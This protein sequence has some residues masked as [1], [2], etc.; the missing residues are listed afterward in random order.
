MCV[1]VQCEGERS[2]HYFVMPRWD[3]MAGYV[4]IGCH[5]SETDFDD[6]YVEIS[7]IQNSAFQRMQKVSGNS[8]KIW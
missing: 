1:F 3:A 6:F 8:R 5:N 4:D 2:C 7:D